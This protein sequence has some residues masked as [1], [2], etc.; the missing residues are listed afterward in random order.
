[1]CLLIVLG[2][3]GIRKL[4]HFNKAL[5]GKGLW[6]FGREGTH[7]WRRVIAT[8]YGEGQRGWTTKACRRARECGLWH[9][10]HDGWESFSKH[11]ALV[12]GDGTRIHF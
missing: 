6:R 11:V 2:G 5:L 3:L 7:L 4:V 10:I 9:G 12:V 1:M 8:K